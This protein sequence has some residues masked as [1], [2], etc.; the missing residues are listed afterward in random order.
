MDDALPSAQQEVNFPTT[1]PPDQKE[2]IRKSTERE[3]LCEQCEDQMCSMLCDLALSQSKFP[4]SLVDELV[5]DF[6]GRIKLTRKGQTVEGWAKAGCPLAQFLIAMV[7]DA[8]V[9]SRISLKSKPR[10]F[11]R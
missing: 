9:H 1:L 8:D 4:P 6:D 5:D 3:I 11:Q 2:Q 10:W 7:G